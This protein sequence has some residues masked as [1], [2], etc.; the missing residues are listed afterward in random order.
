MRTYSTSDKDSALLDH[1]LNS[2]QF[3]D[4][5]GSEVPDA[6]VFQVA[7]EFEDILSRVWD[8]AS[9]T[10]DT[11]DDRP[12]AA[13]MEAVMAAGCSNIPFDGSTQQSRVLMWLLSSWEVCF[14]VFSW[15][16][17]HT[18]AVHVCI[19]PPNFCCAPSTCLF[20]TCHRL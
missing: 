4:L 10:G 8:S 12:L 18:T 17:Q 2:F 3:Y 14:G 6:V 7:N 11:G 13:A 1:D 5:D 20:T 15:D 19:C 9:A 16:E